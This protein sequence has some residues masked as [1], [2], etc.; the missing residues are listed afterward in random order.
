MKWNDHHELEGLHA[1]L[2]ASQFHWI[3]WQEEDVVARYF[4]SFSQAIGTALHE[5]ACDCV[6]SK[7]VLN[8]NDIPLIKLTMYKAYI[9]EQAY[10]AQLL[11]D[12]LM[13]F[14]NDG[15]RDG[16]STE[17][18]LY[19]SPFCFGT[20]DQ[21]RFFENEKVLKIKDLKSGR[22]KTHMEQLEIYAALFCLEYGYDPNDIT[23]ELSIYQRGE[24]FIFN[25]QSYEIT[26]IMDL[27]KSRDAL[28]QQALGKGVTTQYGQ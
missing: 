5:L 24:V 14:V 16:M 26:T 27:I 9:P 25:P 6:R 11:L 1:F 12:T 17:V 15:I 7:T 22:T 28:I 8:E 10:D 4:G 23:I 13:P 20:A 19:Y 3:N 21:I 2:G 18:L